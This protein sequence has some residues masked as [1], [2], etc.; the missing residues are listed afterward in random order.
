MS[1]SSVHAPAPKASGGGADGGAGTF[2]LLRSHAPVACAHSRLDWSERLAGNARGPTANR[3]TIRLFG[4]PEDFALSLGLATASHRLDSRWGPSSRT[5]VLLRVEP[6]GLSSWLL[7]NFSHLLPFLLSVLLFLPSLPGSTTG[8]TSRSASL[9][10]I[11][12]G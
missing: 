4:I 6:H 12:S 9:S 3:V 1:S 2:C 7:L 11:R 8:S 5:S 10:F